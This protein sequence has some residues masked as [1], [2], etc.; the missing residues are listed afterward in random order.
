LNFF[1]WAI[2]DEILDYI[3]T[4]H[5]EI[6]KDMDSRIQIMKQSDPQQL[7]KRHEISNSATKSLK[8]NE[9]RVSVKFD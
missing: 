8:I 3:E 2:N 5:D 9:M 4:H 7:K 6:H 1:E